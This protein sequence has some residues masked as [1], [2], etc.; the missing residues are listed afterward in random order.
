M[1][2]GTTIL[3][4]HGAAPEA[5]E[6][7]LDAVFTGEEL[8]RALRLE[9]T[10]RAVLARAADPDL[11]APYRYLICRPHPASAWTPVVDLGGPADGL[12]V[13]LSRQLD[14]AAVF[15]A[16]SYGDVRSGYRL[17]RGGALVDQYVSDPT[18]FSSD[19]EVPAA[20]IEAQRG[21]PERFADLFPANTPPEDF[22]RVVLRPG[23]WEGHDAAADRASVGGEGG[24]DEGEEADLVDE[25]DRMRCIAL[26]LELWGPAEYPFAGELDELPNQMVGPVI[27]LAYA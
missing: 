22:A 15:T 8:H 27:A 23:W 4:V 17:A 7:A 16:F 13:E 1:E 21:H 5:V 20:E 3:H 26:G 10:Y 2:Y 18:S 25:V 6:R 19:D 11:Q 14:G 9:G 24:E 12:D